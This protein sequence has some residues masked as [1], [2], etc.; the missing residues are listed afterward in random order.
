M[1][2]TQKSKSRSYSPAIPLL[3]IK[4]KKPLMQEDTCI[5]MFTVALFIIAKVYK[6]HKYP[7]Q[8]SSLQSLSHVRLCD[9]MNRST[10]GLP[11]INHLPEF[12]QTHIH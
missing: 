8:F 5:L 3:G 7:V 6:Q 10:P 11:V 4:K 9:P 1:K 2:I 12:T